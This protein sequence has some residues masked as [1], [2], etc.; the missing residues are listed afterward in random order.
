MVFTPRATRWELRVV[1]EFRVRYCL[2]SAAMCN[3]VPKCVGGGYALKK[4]PLTKKRLPKFGDSAKT[5]Q[6]RSL[7]YAMM[8]TFKQ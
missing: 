8:D 5:I 4:Y 3:R 7:A 2:E 1:C 6:R